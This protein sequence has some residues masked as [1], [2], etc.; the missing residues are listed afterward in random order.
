MSTALYPLPWWL[1]VHSPGLASC[2]GTTYRTVLALAIAYWAGHC[3]DLPTDETS[4]ACL[5]RQPMNA[6]KQA[7]HQV[8]PTLQTI[9]PHLK[10][11]HDRIDATRHKM[12]Q[13]AK[14]ATAAS[15]AARLKRTAAAQPQRPLISPTRSP[16]ASAR[17]TPIAATT[18][19]NT[20]STGARFTD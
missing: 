11:E 9:L 8:L 2:S 4:L 6:W 14:Q 16:V 10:R 5:A 12:R 19:E 13:L 3:T 17:R 7:K 20:T 1:I 18:A 15:V